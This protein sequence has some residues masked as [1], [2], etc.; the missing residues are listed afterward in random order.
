MKRKP[1]FDS[2]LPA[3]LFIAMGVLCLLSMPGCTQSEYTRLVQREL[4]SGERHDSLFL[5]IHFGMSAQAFYTHCWQLNLE[6]TIK[7]GSGNRSVLYM[8]E[9]FS[10]P[11]NMNF[12][13]IFSTEGDRNIWQ[14][15]VLFDYVA[16][17]LWSKDFHS[18]Q[19]LPEVLALLDRWY[20][21]EFIR[22]K[23]PDGN[24]EAYVKV[25]GNRR[26]I[27]F[28][29]DNQYVQATFTDL[30]AANEVKK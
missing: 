8:P 5:G 3:L 1:L 20:E 24:A 17:A 12:Y 23:T 25:N 9:G 30:L 19:L 11:V 13:P 7:E 14:M 21:G 4:A 16:W 27:V 15:P 18:D 6:G 2:T 29:K 28:C 26:I 22:M 10:S